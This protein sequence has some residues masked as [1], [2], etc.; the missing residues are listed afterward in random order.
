M[1]D[2]EII[3]NMYLQFLKTRSCRDNSLN[4]ISYTSKLIILGITK[5]VHG[6]PNI[7]FIRFLEFLSNGIQNFFRCIKAS[8][9]MNNVENW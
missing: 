1:M 9:P 6:I 7:R 3:Y 4:L 2:K 8:T 5:I